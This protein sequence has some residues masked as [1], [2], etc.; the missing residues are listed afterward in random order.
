GE[1]PDRNAEYL[2]YQTLVGAWPI[3]AERVVA[4]IQKAAREA[5]T[6]TSWTDPRPAYEDALSGFIADALSD[7]RFL[8]DLE[9][10]VAPLI[11]EGLPKLWTIRQALGF[12][13][14]R[15]ELFGPQG[16]YRPLE[17][18]GARASHA[19]VFMR[20]D[21]A[22]TIA[23]RLPIGLGGDWGDT[24]LDVPDGRWRNE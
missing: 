15:P 5:K 13:R 19:L 9:A 3:D 14:R 11:D 16:D 1:W 24:S 20:G 18:R 7:P 23:P 8:A 10:F 12:R 4:Y 17:A 22:I 21:A 6:H 2:L